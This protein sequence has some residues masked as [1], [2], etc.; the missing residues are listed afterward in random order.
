MVERRPEVEECLA[1][2]H[3]PLQRQLYEAMNMQCVPSVRAGLP[4]EGVGSLVEVLL[5]PV[6]EI[7][8]VV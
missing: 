2:D 1:C 3:A 7:G 4:C 5:D 6:I 8:D